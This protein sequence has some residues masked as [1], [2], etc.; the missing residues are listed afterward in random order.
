MLPGPSYA[1]ILRAIGEDL[2]AANLRYFDIRIEGKDYVVKPAT[3][4]E[5]K[6][7]RYT[8]EDIVSL[9][10]EGR[11]KRSDPL[12]TPDFSS[13]SQILRAIGYYIDRKDGY[14]LEISKA[15]PSRA[16]RMLRIQYKTAMANRI[17]EE[18]SASDVY[19]LCVRMYKNRGQ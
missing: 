17:K 4:F 1:Q 15:L 14:L 5:P 12:R 13:I 8:P 18:F 16:G 3:S 9:E 10:R 11:A 7:R 2:E 19:A 6:I